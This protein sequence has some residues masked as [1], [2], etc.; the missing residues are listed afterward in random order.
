LDPPERE[1]SGEYVIKG[2][3][4]KWI[5]QIMRTDFISSWALDGAQPQGTISQS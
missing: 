1:K 5:L 2:Q 3:G 4:G